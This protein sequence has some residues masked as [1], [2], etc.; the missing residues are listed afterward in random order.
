MLTS[1]ASPFSFHKTMDHIRVKMLRTRDQ[2]EM[3]EEYLVLANLA[4]LLVHSGD[5]V[6]FEQPTVGPSETK[7]TYPGELKGTAR[8]VKRNG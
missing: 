3:G 8:R 2:L 7:P 1:I 5:A 6:L 4:A